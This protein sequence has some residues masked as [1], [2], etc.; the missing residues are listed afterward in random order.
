MSTREPYP[1]DLSDEEWALIAPLVPPNRGQGRH[2]PGD[3]REVVNALFYHTA[4]GC[5]WR[6]LPHDFPE[7]PTVRYYFDK[8]QRDGT[9]ERVNE[10]LRRA[11][12]EEADRDPEPTAG[13]MDSQSVK[14]TEQGGVRGYDAGKHIW[15]RKRHILVDTLGNLLYACVHG[16]DLQDAAGAAIVL[17]NGLAAVPS[18]ELVWVDGGYDREALHLWV[19]INTD[20]TLE[21]VRRPREAKGFVVLPR[22][23]VVERTLAW[24]SRYRRLARDYERLIENSTAHVYIASIHVMVRRLARLRAERRANESAIAISQAA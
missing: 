10:A 24:L 9:W 23:W 16:A 7:W 17:E 15:G 3:L 2:P 1:S 18:L 20:I 12:R 5:R 6:S 21:V 14:T 19:L 4:E 11:L 8:W 22:R 13:I